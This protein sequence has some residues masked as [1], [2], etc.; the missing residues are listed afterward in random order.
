MSNIDCYSDTGA[1]L[2]GRA[3]AQTAVTTDGNIITVDPIVP[4]E[5]TSFSATIDKNDVILSW[6]TATET[7]NQGFEIQRRNINQSEYK[8]VGFVEGNGTTTEVKS[9]TFSEKNVFTGNYGYRLKQVDYDGTF[10]YSEEIKV[11][12][13]PTLEYSV[14]QNYPNPFNPTSTIQYTIPKMGFVKISIYNILGNEI[15]V[16]ISEEKIPG[17]YEITFNAKELASGIYF[18][19]IRTGEFSQIK[20]MT[21]MK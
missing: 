4:V 5:L 18:Y 10:E 13:T 6:S 1:T 19:K 21:L 9:Y 16:L 20:K 12:M 7:N 8:I 17:N 15:K 2:N 3:L 14:S 11:G